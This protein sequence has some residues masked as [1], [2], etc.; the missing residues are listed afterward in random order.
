M[1]SQEEEDQ[2]A[3]AIELSLKEASS[4]PRNYGTLPSSLYPSTNLPLTG[5]S[6]ATP[7]KEL[8]KVRALY[9]FEAAE[10]NEL[11]FTSGELI[12][13]I[14]SSDPN[15]WK[16]SNH[17]G[18]GLFPAN[19]VTSDLNAEPEPEKKK[20]SDVEEDNAKSSSSTKEL[21]ELENVEINEEKIDRLLHLLHEADPTNS[22]K[23]TLE[24]QN[25]ES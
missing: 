16:G 24:M 19:F 9:D 10:D 13:V 1:Q 25:L 17:R 5:P 14:D 21:Q 4:S 7:P 23:D 12:L 15:W 2:I 20:K 22:D 18:E 6:S 3:K 11:T 8:R